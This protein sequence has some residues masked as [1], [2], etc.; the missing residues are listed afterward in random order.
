MERGRPF[1]NRLHAGRL[2]AGELDAAGL[3]R[4]VVLGLARGGV[5]VA[6]EVARALGAE[7]DVLV[8]RKIGHPEQPEWALGAVSEDGAVVGDVGGEIAH[9]EAEAEL[10][11]A[12]AQAAALRGKRPRAV[13]A[14]RAAVVVD[15]GLATGLSMAAALQSV[16][17][18]GAQRCVMAVPVA[19]SPGFDTVSSAAACEACAVVVDR[20]ARHFAVGS[21]YADFTQV[22]DEEVRRLLGVGA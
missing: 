19:A 7:L 11:A 5:P 1:E 10:A 14:G 2:L 16:R 15:D 6:A 18:A 13:L 3:E 22:S 9:S 4:A 20:G 12:R 8:V 17:A 21:Y